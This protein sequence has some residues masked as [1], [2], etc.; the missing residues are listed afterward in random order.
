MDAFNDERKEMMRASQTLFKKKHASRGGYFVKVT[1]A[2]DAPSAEIYTRPMFDVAWAPIISVL[3]HAFEL[4]GDED[5]ELLSASL[6]GF[7]HAIRL[8]CRLGL[9]V[10]RSTY[11]NA[12]SNFTAL[13]MVRE[14]RSKNLEAVKAL[15]GVAFTEGDYLGPSWKEVFTC[16]SRLSRLDQYGVG[17]HLDEDFFT[18]ANSKHGL[19]D[20]S[21]HS[22]L[23]SVED[24]NA[25][26]VSTEVDMLELDRIFLNSSKLSQESVVDFVRELCAVSKEELLI[27]SGIVAC[28]TR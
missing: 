9:P 28:R 16:I 12:L 8:A 14:M 10:V 5:P 6:E 3:S 11:M 18:D 19:E 21:S 4:H 27:A 7:K 24:A 13:D 2:L 23:K 25:S 15:I 20:E 26:L 22:K 17:G 1:T